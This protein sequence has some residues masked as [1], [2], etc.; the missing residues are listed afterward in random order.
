MQPPPHPKRGEGGSSSM[1]ACQSAG[2]AA[3]NSRKSS[4]VFDL[5]HEKGR[6]ARAG[7]VLGRAAVCMACS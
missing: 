6:E 2:G 3:A 7:Q 4:Y 5:H 1:G